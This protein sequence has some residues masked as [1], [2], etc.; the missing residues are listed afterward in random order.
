M[1]TLVARWADALGGAVGPAMTRAQAEALLEP[2]V[3]RLSAVLR[4]EPFVP[5]TAKQIGAE[6]VA[7]NYRDPIVVSR[8]I[9]FIC[10]DLADSAAAPERAA[11]VAGEFAEGFVASL[12]EVS[13]AEQ[14]TTLTA[15]LAAASAA[16]TRRRRSDLRFHAVF[17]GASVGIGTIDPRGLV[18]DVNAAMADMLGLPVDKIRGRSVAEVLGADNAGKAFESFKDLL[19]GRTTGFRLETDHLR[20]D[21]TVTHI[22]LSMTAM[23]DVRGELDFLIG[24][25][26]DVTERRRLADKLWYDAHHDTLTGL[27]NRALF[28]ES[29]RESNRPIGLCYLDL[30]GFKRVN[31]DR[32]HGTGD[33]VL[34]AVAERLRAV[35]ERDNA[36]VARLG[37][38][39]FIMLI[40]RCPV[41]GP[42]LAAQRI[43]AALAPPIP[44]K[45]EP[46][47][48]TASVGV[49]H[50]ATIG[51]DNDA[52]M[53]AVDM[54]M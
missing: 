50:S 10:C 39:E 5:G 3:A 26:V 47:H 16:E 40:E 30:D 7:A 49:V 31:D 41:D 32:G 36:L 17:T 43:V 34:R 22:D 29:L 12:R 35:A 25:G 37:G 53:H 21:G 48:I 52:L 2:L 38:D 6:L 14:E 51:D 54:A 28:F 9:P 1:R 44:G 45:G 33:N 20:P 13:L 42:T 24:I 8:S 27:A 46:I 4:E 15:A 19:S 23:F 18:T 11:A